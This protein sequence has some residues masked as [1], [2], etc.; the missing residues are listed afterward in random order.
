[1]RACVY[2]LCIYYVS[3]SLCVNVCVLAS[4]LAV[5][6]LLAVLQAGRGAQQRADSFS[7]MGRGSLFSLVPLPLSFLPAPFLQDPLLVGQSLKL[8]HF[9]QALPLLFFTEHAVYFLPPF[10]FSQFTL[11]RFLFSD[12][13]VLAQSAERSTGSF[14]LLLIKV[15]ITV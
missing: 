3:A 9:S 14:R 15:A 12:L 13:P 4:F 2:S 8:K 11:I 6:W 7:E 5:L 1:M 10:I